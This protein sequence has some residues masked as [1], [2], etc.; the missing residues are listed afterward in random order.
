ME[1]GSVWAERTQQFHYTE[2]LVY[3]QNLLR[4][5]YRSFSF[6]G[7]VAKPLGDFEFSGGAPCGVQGCGFSDSRFSLSRW[8]IPICSFFA[9]GVIRTKEKP[10]P[11]QK[12]KL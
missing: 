3:V 9:G 5:P 11:S 7:R 12:P 2:T 4:T 6:A 1:I 10:H 8:P